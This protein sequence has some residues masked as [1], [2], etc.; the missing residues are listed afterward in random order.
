[1]QGENLDIANDWSAGAPQSS[2]AEHAEAWHCAC[3]LAHFQQHLL[4]YLTYLPACPDCPLTIQLSPHLLA[5]A[6][7]SLPC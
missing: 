3:L 4:V 6:S 5:A 7:P 2:P 1:M